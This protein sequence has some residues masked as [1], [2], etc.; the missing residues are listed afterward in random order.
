MYN[1]HVKFVTHNEAR[2]KYI[3]MEKSVLYI[4][5]SVNYNMIKECY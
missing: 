1:T 3:K 2:N 4:T 5:K